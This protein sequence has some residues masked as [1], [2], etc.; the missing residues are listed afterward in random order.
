MSVLR[1]C[2]LIFG[3]CLGS[4][5]A[6]HH[7][8][9]D[10]LIYGAT[11]TSYESS[12]LHEDEVLED[13]LV[14]H[15]ERGN[16]SLSLRRDDEPIFLKLDPDTVTG[17]LYRER[18]AQ[19]SSEYMRWVREHVGNRDRVMGYGTDGTRRFKLVYDEEFIEDKNSE[20][21]FL[22]SM[23]SGFILKAGDFPL[24]YETLVQEYKKERGGFPLFDYGS[25]KKARFN[26]RQGE[27]EAYLMIAYVG[28]KLRTIA[29][30]G[31]NIDL[32]LGHWVREALGTAF[33]RYFGFDTEP[34]LQ[35]TGERWSRYLAMLEKYLKTL[36]KLKSQP[37]FSTGPL[38]SLKDFLEKE[39]PDHYTLM[40]FGSPKLR[41]AHTSLKSQVSKALNDRGRKQG[42]GEALQDL[43]KA[44]KTFKE[45]V[46]SEAKTHNQRLKNH[47]SQNGP[48]TLE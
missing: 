7:L 16:P 25:S 42:K 17:L 24:K 45:T 44:L 2:I 18:E 20:I 12:V 39:D 30:S 5:F 35:T 38:K 3:A 40:I 6:D 15:K 11:E 8:S 19:S 37:E 9:L 13:I 21:S 4:S 43:E 36:G 41:E 47:L 31:A 14:R 23:V 22:T 10:D 33:F 28:G 34:T 26:L 1:F 32:I 29:V 46:D 27:V 48:V